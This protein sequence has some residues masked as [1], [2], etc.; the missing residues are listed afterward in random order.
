[1]ID[2]EDFTDRFTEKRLEGKDLEDGSRLLYRLRPAGK[3]VRV[4]GKRRAGEGKGKKTVDPQSPTWACEKPTEKTFRG[5]TDVHKKKV[6]G[7]G[8]NGLLRRQHRVE[9][10]RTSPRRGQTAHGKKRRLTFLPAGRA[11]RGENRRFG[12]GDTACRQRTYFSATRSKDFLLLKSSSLKEL[13]PLDGKGGLEER[14]IRKEI[15]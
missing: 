1:V 12:K 2:Q 4:R 13:E 3:K 10:A 8:K 14:T 11:Y 6:R 5:R 7:L 15:S 9:T